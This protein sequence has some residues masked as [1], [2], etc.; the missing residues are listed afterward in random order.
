MARILAEAKK[1]SAEM[2]FNQLLRP[3]NFE[4]LIKVTLEIAAGDDSPILSYSMKI[5]HSL[6]RLVDMLVSECIKSGDANLEHE[7]KQMSFLLRSDWSSRIS[8]PAVKLYKMTKAE[9]KVR[10][11]FSFSEI[12]YYSC[13]MYLLSLHFSIKLCPDFFIS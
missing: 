3:R 11:Y 7:Y 2:S 5:T 4:F 12:I 13:N 1:T 9:K 8:R 10:N 6:H